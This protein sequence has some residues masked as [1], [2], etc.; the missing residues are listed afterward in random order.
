[1]LPFL[2][3]LS[4]AHAAPAPEDQVDVLVS[5]Q[6]RSLMA[7]ISALR[8][9]EFEREVPVTVESPEDIR[10]ESMEDLQEPEAQEALEAMRATLR[11]FQLAPPGADV[12]AA[13]ADIMKESLGGYY[14]SDERRLVLVEHQGAM[15]TAGL[16]PNSEEAMTA[17]HELVHALQDQNF[18]LWNMLNRELMDDDVDLALG[19]LVEGDA[20]LAMLEY[21]NPGSWRALEPLQRADLV[22]MMSGETVL[23]ADSA[24]GRAP[25]ILR[26]SLLFP[27]G[28]GLAFVA[29]LHETGGWA[30]IDQAFAQ[31]PL[32]S[33]QILHPERY[34]ADTPDWPIRLELPDLAPL[35]GEGWR[36]VEE[37]TFGEAGIRSV[38]RDHL[39]HG[40]SREQR[41]AAGGWGGDRYVV[42]R[43]PSDDAWSG[44]WLTTWDS[45]D[46]AREFLAI[47]RDEV[48]SLAGSALAHRGGAWQATNGRGTWSVSQSGNDVLLL[49]G[50]PAP[51]APD[52]RSA[53]AQV[54]RHRLTTLEQV[55]PPK[56][57]PRKADE[58]AAP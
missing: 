5:A 38:L 36:A 33:E 51:V 45:A 25:R 41:A 3:L 30:R 29:G 20:S 27:Y 24:L 26:E 57:E 54:P 31:P 43:G 1:M 34:T 16:Q 9:L 50:A 10:A 22:E 53:L 32:S 18:D 55:A 6:V 23:D 58:P 56:G 7:T 2:V 39:P 15:S 49:L 4:A 13:Y 12:G 44:V 35:Y 28:H 46:D 21:T 48:A 19:A 47:A 14:S 37:N 17:A 52:L 11:A 8:K 40:S 42:L